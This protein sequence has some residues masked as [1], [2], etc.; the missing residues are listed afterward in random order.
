MQNDKPKIVYPFKDSLYIN[1]T[2]RCPNA[3]RFCLKNKFSM[4]FEGFNLNLCGKEPSASEVLEEVHSLLKEKGQIKELVFCG[5][6]EPTMQLNVLL[7][8]AKALKADMQ[9]G[10]IKPF[11][12]RLNTVGLGSLVH[13]YDI[14]PDLA[15]VLDKINISLNAPSKDKW[16]ELV[17]PKKEYEAKGYESVLSFIAAS[18]QRIPD[19]VVSIVAGQDIDLEKTKKLVETLGAKLYVRPLI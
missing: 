1:L 3:C 10:Y 18:A 7:K 11:L 9:S 4:Q 17:R 2:N 16:L 8:V 14:T 13:G 15:N 19:T 6:G 12:I 5:Y